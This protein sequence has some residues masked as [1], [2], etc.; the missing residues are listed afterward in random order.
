A[1]FGVV[2]LEMI[3]GHV[4]SHYLYV[5]DEGVGALLFE[6]AEDT[7]IVGAELEV[8]FLDEIVDGLPGGI[9]EAVGCTQNDGREEP[10]KAADELFP[11]VGAARGRAVAHEFLDRQGGVAL[12]FVPSG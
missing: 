8:G 11:R 7:R 4:G 10:M 1:L 12:H 6:T 3:A 5:T 9:A 2:G